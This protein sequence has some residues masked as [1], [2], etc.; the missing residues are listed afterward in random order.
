MV[1]TREV[2]SGHCPSP[3]AVL[4]RT[5]VAALRTSMDRSVRQPLKSLVISLWAELEDCPIPLTVLVMHV[6]ASTR[7]YT[8]GTNT[9]TR[10]T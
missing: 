7:Y 2:P 6:S 9:L 1:T 8:G 3:H 10:L 4:V 5:S